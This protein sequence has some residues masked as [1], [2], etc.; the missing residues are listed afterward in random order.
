MK[1][2]QS[3]RQVGL[4]ASL[5][6]VSEG[7]PQGRALPG[8][9]PLVTAAQ[10]APGKGSFHLLKPHPPTS[11]CKNHPDSPVLLEWCW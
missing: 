11:C 7:A 5:A 2:S 8:S 9:G 4:G 10:K 3:V 1:I 6:S